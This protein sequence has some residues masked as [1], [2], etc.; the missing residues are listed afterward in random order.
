MQEKEEG[1]P[2]LY[3]VHGNDCLPDRGMN[4]ILNDPLGPMSVQSSQSQD[5]TDHPEGGGNFPQPVC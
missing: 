1:T 4:C 5:P 2:S 3:V